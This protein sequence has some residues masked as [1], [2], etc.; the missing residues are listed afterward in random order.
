MREE[1]TIFKVDHICLEAGTITMDGYDHVYQKRLFSDGIGY[2][3]AD[4]HYFQDSMNIWDHLDVIK[5][6]YEQF[7]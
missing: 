1:E 5:P 7:D 6:L 3:T 2:V 4:L